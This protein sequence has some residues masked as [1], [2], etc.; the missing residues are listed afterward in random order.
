[1]PIK[2]VLQSIYSKRD[3]NG[4]CYWSFRFTDTATGKSVEGTISGGESNVR[5]MLGPLGLSGEEVH[6]ST[7][8]LPIREW[9]RLTKEFRYAGCSAEQLASF[10]RLE[11][12]KA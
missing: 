10:V 8:E 12:A 3:R 2:A 6:S 11:L 1:V 4:N 9:N 5:S 7:I